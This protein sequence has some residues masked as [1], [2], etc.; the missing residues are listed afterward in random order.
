MKIRKYKEI[1]RTFQFKKLLNL[2]KISDRDGTQVLQIL[3]MVNLPTI[4][5]EFIYNLIY[6]FAFLLY[7]RRMISEKES[8]DSFLPNSQAGLRLMQY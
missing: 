4:L 5:N 8:R 7:V 6:N 2:S 3:K 1:I